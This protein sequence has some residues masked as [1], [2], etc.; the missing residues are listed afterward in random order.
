MFIDKDTYGNT[1]MSLC[2]TTMSLN[3]LDFN[4][5]V[6]LYHHFQ[7]GPGG[8]PDNWKRKTLKFPEIA[9]LASKLVNIQFS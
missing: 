5:N 9:D 7:E 8:I 4:C 1:S 2:Y 6:F 3:K